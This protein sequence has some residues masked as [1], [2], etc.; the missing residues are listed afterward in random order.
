M[1]GSTFVRHL[2]CVFVFYSFRSYIHANWTMFWNWCRAELI[3][4]ILVPA[5]M[6]WVRLWDNVQ[7]IAT[8]KTDTQNLR[9]Q[10]VQT[11]PASPAVV[12]WNREF[13]QLGYGFFREWVISFPLTVRDRVRK[14]MCVVCC[15]KTE[16][17][18][19]RWKKPCTWQRVHFLFHTLVIYH[20]NNDFKRKVIKND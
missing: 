12:P 20:C 15:S 13:I 10:R 2:F 6:K 4:L 18:S 7:V 3:A 5:G 8:G 16:P 14:R 9:R 17:R 11:W 1:H 19:R